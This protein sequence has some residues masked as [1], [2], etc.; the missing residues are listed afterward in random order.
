MCMEM[1]FVMHKYAYILFIKVF[2]IYYK[3]KKNTYI[4]MHL[5]LRELQH[6]E[7]NEKE[8]KGCEASVLLTIK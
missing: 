2:F 7:V 3:L 4:F 5:Y 1:I 8:L 6:I